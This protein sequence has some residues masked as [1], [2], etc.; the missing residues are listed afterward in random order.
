[1]PARDRASGLAVPARELVLTS[2]EQFIG[3]KREL[4]QLES[5]IRRV[6]GGR[7]GA[8][9]VLGEPG[10]GKTRLLAEGIR[11]AAQ[12]GART[13]R[14]A[15]LPVTT[16][17]AFD[18]ALELLR[19]LGLSVPPAILDGPGH[20]LFGVLVQRLQD[21][22]AQGPIL[23]CLDDLQ[24]SDA[25][26]ID[27]VHYCL[28]RLGDLPI[29]WL[30]VARSGRAAGRLAHRLQRDDLVE[31]LE[32]GPLSQAETRLLAQSI[33]GVDDPG[34]EL[35]RAVHERS[36]GNAFFSAELLR[37]VLAAGVDWSG[38]D[39]SP[40]AVLDAVVPG[41][42]GDAV[43]ERAARLTRPARE[44]LDW[45]AV[46][47]E[48]FSFRDL[49]TVGGHELGVAPEE[50]ADA[51]FLAAGGG[52]DWAFAHAIIHDAVY[53]GLPEAERVRRHNVV[54]DRLG[55]LPLERLAP[56]LERAR[57]HADAS[58]AYAQL[59]VRSLNRGLGDDAVRLFA[60][61][62]WLADEARDARLRQRAEAGRVLALLRA[63][64]IGAARGDAAQLR[65]EMRAGAAPGERVRFLS[66]YAMSLMTVLDEIDLEGA[67]DAVREAEPLI[68]DVEGAVLAEALVA[69]G[70]LRLR[71]GE[72]ARALEDAEAAA[73][74]SA[75]ID[76][77]ELEV[78]T[79]NLL[80]LAAGFVRTAAEGMSI[81]ERARDR[82]LAAGLPVQAARACN[83]LAFFAEHAGEPEA[84][85]LHSRRGL[86]IGGAPAILTAFLHSNLGVSLSLRGDLDGAMAHLLAAVGQLTRSGAQAQR[87]FATS[88]AYVHIWRGEL[89]AARR[90]LESH[91]MQTSLQTDTRVHELRGMLFEADGNLT[92][93]VDAFARGMEVADPNSMWCAAATVRTAVAAGQL[94]R[95][96]DAFGRLEGLVRQWPVGGWM[97]EEACGWLGVADSR[98]GDAVQH[99]RAA[100]R[101][102]TRAHDRARLRLE[103]AR[104]AGDRGEILAAIEDF[105]R[106]GALG[107]A[108][109]GRAIAREL[110]M[111]PRRRGRKTGLLS[112]REQEIAQLVAAGNTNAEIADTLFLSPRTV[113][114]HVGNI[115]TKLGFRS[116]VQIAAEAAAGRLPGAVLTQAGSV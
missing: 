56:Q 105:E 14:T 18:P 26:T 55:E 74:L 37:A 52:G 46:L 25:A 53:R 79:L 107:S 73:A 81:L 82:G 67:A 99:M 89:N 58:V 83:N 42:V 23:L 39:A 95:A 7:G 54:V 77:P 92:G 63:G 71:H 48:R 50:L 3:R 51:G 85:A 102:C 66:R 116:R 12:H 4:A 30:L 108:N 97:R 68:P 47:P 49:E 104:L 91:D 84:V 86:A 80:G 45:A 2:S 32:L 62:G 106:M 69:R 43:E 64:G 27:L 21:A 10:A 76:D 61:A 5:T 57:R 33:L 36:A 31:P 111:R 98:T 17:L 9:F 22:A 15:C 103:A 65:A 72:S 24:W 75:K 114:R 113:E 115:L 87:R 90:L 34:P 35:V 112:D 59:A 93:A 20:E 44:A 94:E 38:V 6:S 70:W 11:I 109:R 60:H 96:R 110:G 100:S 41:S 101:D 78:S 29:A 16:Q 19:Q 40:G 28:A 8:L 13:A 1:M 88:L